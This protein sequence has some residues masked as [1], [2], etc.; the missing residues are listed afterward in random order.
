MRPPAH[1]D[2]GAR[3]VGGDVPSH[4]PEGERS[5]VAVPTRAQHHV[6]RA[7]GQPDQR[8]RRVAV[9]LNAIDLE[10]GGG[11]VGELGGRPA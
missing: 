5:E 3:R 6:V 2:D 9:E 7:G 10:T 4:R 8:R 1:D 11:L